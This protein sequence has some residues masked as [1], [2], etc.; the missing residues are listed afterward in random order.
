MF[1][2][3][4]TAFSAKCRT[5]HREVVAVMY[6]SEDCV[7]PWE[8]NL[9]VAE[10]DGRVVVRRILLSLVRRHSRSSV[11]ANNVKMY[12]DICHKKAVTA[13]TWS[14]APHR[15]SIFS[16][17]TSSPLPATVTAPSPEVRVA[18]GTELLL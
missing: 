2:S 15:G 6:A 17:L 8:T 1:E 14:S 18:G 10:V 12:V 11:V 16:Q 4:T 7:T 9:Y 3:L 13:T 5:I